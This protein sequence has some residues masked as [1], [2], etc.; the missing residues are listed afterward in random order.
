MGN[1]KFPILPFAILRIY[2]VCPPPDA[3]LTP[4]CHAPLFSFLGFLPISLLFFFGFLNPFPSPLLFHVI[5]SGF[6]AFLLFDQIGTSPHFL[7]HGFLT[8]NLAARVFEESSTVARVLLKVRLNN[9]YTSLLFGKS[10]VS[11]NDSQFLADNGEGEGM[12]AQ[13]FLEFLTVERVKV[14]MTVMLTLALCNADRVVTSV[15]IVH[16]SQSHG[17]S[18]AFAGVFQRVQTESTIQRFSITRSR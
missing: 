7:S 11:S 6:F 12:E 14:V 15:A 17:W 9:G 5:I 16:L 3:D 1:S 2:G 10:R 8:D 18:R 4:F 13:S